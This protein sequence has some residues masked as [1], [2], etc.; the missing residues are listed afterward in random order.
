[1]ENNSFQKYSNLFL[2]RIQEVICCRRDLPHNLKCLYRLR[3]VLT[4]KYV[5]FY[6]RDISRIPYISILILL[7]SFLRLIHPFMTPL[8]ALLTLLIRS[9]IHMQFTAT[10][11]PSHFHI[12]STSFVPVPLVVSSTWNQRYLSACF[13]SKEGSCY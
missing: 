3:L 7:H 5:L 13:Q 2:N 9:Q 6:S 4:E 8:T 1:M 12:V 10:W 11:R